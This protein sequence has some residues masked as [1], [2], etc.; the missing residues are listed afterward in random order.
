MA[1][2]LTE[3]FTTCKQ[4]T[5]G[6]NGTND[7]TVTVNYDD[8][9]V[10]TVEGDGEQ[11]FVVGHIYPHQKGRVYPTQVTRGN[12]GTSDAPQNRRSM[13]PRTTALRL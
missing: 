13:L 1:I 6:Y 9:I 2:K 10:V 8:D 4:I 7:I 11:S 3:E 12:A 5:V